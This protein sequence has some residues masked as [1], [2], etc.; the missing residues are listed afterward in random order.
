[1]NSVA[2]AHGLLVAYPAQPMSAN[3]SLCWNWFNPA[4]Q[5]RGAGEPSIIAGITRNLMSEFS[6]DRNQVFVAGLSAGG[7]MALVMGETYPDVYAAIGIHSGLPYKSANDVMSAF[8]AMRGEDS[9]PPPVRLHS[10]ADGASTARIIVFQ[11]SADSTV[12]PTN[13]NKILAADRHRC[14]A[15]TKPGRA[16]GGRNF[17]RSVYLASNGAP[18]AELWMI[19]GAGHA[20]SGGCPEGSYTDP[21][22]PDASGEMVRFFLAR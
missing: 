12:H 10:T 2:E 8:A 21:K 7:A 17:Q 9:L 3:G 19:E 16:P 20:W 15:E 22:G 4:D 13:A 5:A 1:M 14:V 11:G 6:L 18:A